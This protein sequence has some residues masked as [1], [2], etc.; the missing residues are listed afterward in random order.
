MIYSLDDGPAAVLLL[1]SAA[2]LLTLALLLD[3]THEVVRSTAYALG[4]A[5]GSITAIA[6]IY[7]TFAISVDLGLATRGLFKATAGIMALT[8]S[9]Y[10]LNVIRLT[11]GK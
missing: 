8:S 5:S 3:H 1:I 2:T 4:T 9:L 7:A 10:G 6:C 11:R